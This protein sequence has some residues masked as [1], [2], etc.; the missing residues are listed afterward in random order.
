MPGIYIHIPYCKRK[1]HYCDFFISTNLSTKND[2]IQALLKEIDLRKMYLP[3]KN[4]S[5]V[6]FGGGTPSLLDSS[7]INKIMDKITAHF[8]VSSDAEITL[9]A[10]PDDLNENYL[11]QLKNTA[12]NRLSIGVQSFSDSDL[13]YMNRIHNS[14][15]SESAIKRAQDKGFVNLSIDLIYALPGMSNLK[16]LQQLETTERLEIPHFSAYCL[17][18]EPATALGYFVRKGIQ[19]AV[20]QTVFAEHFNVLIDFIEK[21]NY[22]QYEISNFCKNEKTA[23]HN[24]SYW[25]GEHYLG[26]GPSAH[27]YNGISRSWNVSHMYDYM[28]SVAEGN[29]KSETENLSDKDRYNEYVLTR[30][31]T[32]W[33]IDLNEVLRD[34]G[35]ENKRHLLK[36]AENYVTKKYLNLVNDKITLTNNGK[37]L[38]DKITSDLLLIE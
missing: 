12:V 13:K 32:M 17:T 28:R 3:Q 33:G 23:K 5:S 38:A 24:S 30:L 9:E 21:Y 15:D 8:S 16:W 6:Y 2:F 36:S 10:N 7:E 14:K 35:M 20:D 18:V 34:F 19:Q 29:V 26:L 25:K 27:S 22:I 11:S 37:L 31:R 1:C 4:I